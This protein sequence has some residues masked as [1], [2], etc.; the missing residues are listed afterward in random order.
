MPPP[1]R[2][3]L[4]LLLLMPAVQAPAQ[5]NNDGPSLEIYGFVMTD[6][7]FDFVRINPDWFDTLRPTQLPSFEHE[8]GRDGSLFSGVRQTRFG[9]KGSEPTRSGQLKTRLSRKRLQTAVLVQA[10]F[11]WFDSVT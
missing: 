5:D 7:G 6:F 2:S 8:F 4:M 10:Q 1:L 9:V 3:A 11:Q